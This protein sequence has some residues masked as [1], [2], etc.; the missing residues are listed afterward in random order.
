MTEDPS[1]LN[2][3]TKYRSIYIYW[4]IINKMEWLQKLNNKNRY[5]RKT[6]TKEVKREKYTMYTKFLEY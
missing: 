1:R 6:S 2:L 3:G 4:N 5:K